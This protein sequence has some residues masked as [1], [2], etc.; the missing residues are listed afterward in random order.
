MTHQD[1]YLAEAFPAEWI[2]KSKQSKKFINQIKIDS[3]DET[4][5]RQKI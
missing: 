2:Q 3:P 5:W 1:K 4:S